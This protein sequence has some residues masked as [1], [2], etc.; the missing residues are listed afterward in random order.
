MQPELLAFE[1]TEP[2]RK[3]FT[4]ELLNEEDEQPAQPP[5]NHATV[6]MV[7][8]ICSRIREAAKALQ[9]RRKDKQ[10]FEVSDEYDVQD[11]LTAALR[12][13]VKD[14]VTEQP[15]EKIANATSSK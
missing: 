12:T 5:Q 10:D 1:L 8:Q 15:L 13:I 4:N 3:D 9:G 7:S 11:L 2:G 14:A 6:A